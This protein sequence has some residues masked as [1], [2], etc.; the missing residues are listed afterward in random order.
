MVNT[1]TEYYVWFRGAQIGAVTLAPGDREGSY[2]GVLRPRPAYWE[3]RPVLQTLTLGIVDLREPS[4]E[5]IVAAIGEAM[6][7]IRAGELELRTEA[8][9]SVAVTQ[10]MVADYSPAEVSAV[11]RDHLPIA[12]YARFGNAAISELNSRDDG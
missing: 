6:Q 4:P 1:G 5:R 9:A 3:H 11:V 12:V 7:Q 2:A 8:G 10:L